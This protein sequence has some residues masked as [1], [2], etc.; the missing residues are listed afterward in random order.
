[1]KYIITIL[2][3]F[4]VC[5]HAED[6]VYELEI[7]EEVDY[8]LLPDDDKMLGWP[9]KDFK[10]KSGEKIQKVVV[11]ISTTKNNLGKW[12]GAFGTSTT[13]APKY[14]YMTDDM[15]EA[16]TKKTGT[17]AWKVDSDTQKI[18][19]Q[20]YGGE[21]KWGV[22]WIDCNDLQLIKLLFILMLMKVLVMMMKMKMIKKKKQKKLKMVF[23]RLKLEIL[24]Y[25]KN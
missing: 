12:T 13:V 4:F 17:I 25:I 8:S 1:M 24:M 14:W 22:W 3:L 10:I 11:H 16:F 6:G 23:T 20:A 7:D 2:F 21:L 5:T 18:I 19:Q 15:N 9:W